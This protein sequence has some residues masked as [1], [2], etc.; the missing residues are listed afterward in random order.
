M[1][2]LL[3]RIIRSLWVPCVHRLYVE[4]AHLWVMKLIRIQDASQIFGYIIGA[5]IYAISPCL[6]YCTVCARREDLK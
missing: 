5:L 1:D 3:S 4:G 6:V 2:L